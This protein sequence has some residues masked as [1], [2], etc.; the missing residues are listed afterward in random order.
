[1]TDTDNQGLLSA[2]SERELTMK[3]LS[4]LALATLSLCGPLS[5][6]RDIPPRVQAM[7][8]QVQPL[9]VPFIPPANRIRIDRAVSVEITAKGEKY[10]EEN[11]ESVVGNVGVSLREGFFPE[12]KYTA[13]E[14]ISFEE[15]ARKS[16]ET[17]AIIQTARSLLQKWFVGLTIQNPRP[18]LKI[19]NAGYRISYARLALVTDR[20]LLRSLGYT[21][22]VVFAVDAA[23]DHLEIGTDNFLLTDANNTWIGVSGF[24]GPLIQSA[25]GRQIKL[26]IPVY[27]AIGD[28]GRIQVKSLPATTGFKSAGIDFSYDQLVT[29][30]ILIEI[31]GQKFLLNKDYLEQIFQDQKPLMIRQAQNLLD[32]MASTKLPEMVN[33]ALGTQLPKIEQINKMSPPGAPEASQDPDFLWG[34]EVRKLNLEDRRLLLELGGWVEDPKN[35]GL[36]FDP[37]L[38]AKGPVQVQGVPTTD[39][40]LAL[41]VN[42]GLINRILQ[43]SYERGYFKEI[44]LSDGESLRMFAPPHVQPPKAGETSVQSEP[45]VRIRVSI[46]QPITGL[47]RLLLHKEVKIMVDVFGRLVQNE[48]GKP[49][50]RVILDSIDDRSLIV[51]DENYTVV[52]RL[53][54]GTVI[55]KIVGNLSGVS[56]GWKTREQAL[57]G[58][59]PLPPQFLGLNLTVFRMNMDPNGYIVMFLN[60]GGEKK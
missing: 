46:L 12:I 56:A 2:S 28:D 33:K 58:A 30:N 45:K 54:K 21:K 10:L 18:S 43:L 9:A 24:K 20:Q 15:I 35:P 13:K 19:T 6:A 4:I 5:S 3:N 25:P 7:Q 17:G 52:G 16:P 32:T 37:A 60:F 31:N 27:V 22:G 40:D 42:R 53:F 14:P 36:H 8:P 51:P 1:M 11:F 57:P 38:A 41:T 23:I 44:A 34:L 59:L 49:G 26:R 47:P 50:M 29:P 55:N 39:Y 48:P